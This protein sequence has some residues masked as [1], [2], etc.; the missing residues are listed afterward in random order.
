M[1]FKQSFSLKAL[2]SVVLI[3]VVRLFEDV[4]YYRANCVAVPVPEEHLLDVVFPVDAP[5]DHFLD[6]VVDVAEVVSD[7]E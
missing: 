2:V 7:V 5:V 4:A 3:E 1:V 6:Q